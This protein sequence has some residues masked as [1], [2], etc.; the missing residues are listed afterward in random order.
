M[1]EY[2]HVTNLQKPYDPVDTKFLD[3]LADYREGPP[4]RPTVPD[5]I[6]YPPKTVE[7]LIAANIV[8]IYATVEAVSARP[9]KTLTGWLAPHKMLGDVLQEE[10]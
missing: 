8:G 10:G 5:P 3:V 7:E 1:S 4:A 2:R 9:I 6:N